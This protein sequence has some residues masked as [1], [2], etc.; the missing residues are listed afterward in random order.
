MSQNRILSE[1]LRAGARIPGN[2]CD[3][4]G[5]VL[6][7]AG[8]CLT[9]AHLSE[10][11]S[12]IHNLLG[13]DDWPD[14]AFEQPRS[15]RR[16]GDDTG[17]AS[18]CEAQDSDPRLAE[19]AIGIESLRVGMRVAR[20]L[21]DDTGVLLLAAGKKITPRSLYLLRTRDIRVLHFLQPESRERDEECETNRDDRA[22]DRQLRVAIERLWTEAQRG[23]DKH[24]H[25]SGAMA[26]ICSA[27]TAGKSA[28]SA[29]VT[30]IIDEFHD[31]LTIDCDLLVTIVGMQETLGEYLFDHC[32]NVAM[33]SMATAAQMGLQRKQVLEIGI[34]AM[35]QDVGMLRV[36]Q[37]I[38]LARRSL[39][40]DERSE[41]RRHP[42][43]SC[44]YLGRCGNLPP[45]A[46]SIA[47]QAHERG[48]GSGYPHGRRDVSLHPLVKIVMV[49]DVYAAMT[50][51]RPYR[52][53]VLPHDAVRELLNGCRTGKYDAAIVRAFLD[54][55]SAF[56]VGSMVELSNSKTGI[57]VR[58]NPGLHT[59]P[60]VA[61]LGPNGER[62]DKLFDLAS[63][64]RLSVTRPLG[65]ATDD[66]GLANQA[67]APTA[68]DVPAVEA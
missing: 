16:V 12:R 68:R 54:C 31:M 46:S 66:K 14:D 10:L 65:L 25:A 42:A 11:G 53:P 6:I 24:T 7:P 37:V 63:V 50:R 61:E 60:V 58:A 27:L 62:T 49:A 48:D 52:P 8:T 33:L 3:S 56:P 45:T 28:S 21:Y 2:L 57:V 23:L 39:S 64:S 35:F 15:T 44:D 32:V 9:D 29:E 1:L 41:V 34:G 51:P 19:G 47:Y 38:R 17:R 55:V 40:E 59:R 26:N 13:G 36:P 18:A 4:S 5:R 30:D 67:D 20:D 43:H 22:D